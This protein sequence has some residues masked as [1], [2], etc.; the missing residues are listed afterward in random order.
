MD[1]ND[2]ITAS[3]PHLR[4]PHRFFKLISD[5]SWIEC[6]SNTG[7]PKAVSSAFIYHPLIC[8]RWIPPL[9]LL[10]RATINNMC[11]PGRVRPDE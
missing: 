6:R 2:V 5:A 8:R 3:L 11:L 1:I 7:R 9:R 4:S 10:G